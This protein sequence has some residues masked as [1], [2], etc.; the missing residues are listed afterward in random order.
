MKAEYF[1]QTKPVFSSDCVGSGEESQDEGF[2]QVF[3]RRHI[4]ISRNFSDIKCQ[5]LFLANVAQ[6]YVSKYDLKEFCKNSFPTI[7]DTDVGH[8]KS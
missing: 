1:R 3:L 5:L 8:Q 6:T 4:W 2:D 7:F